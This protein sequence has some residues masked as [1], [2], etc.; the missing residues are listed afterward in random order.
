MPA[1]AGAGMN[2]TPSETARATPP[3]DKTKTDTPPCPSAAHSK[4]RCAP[5]QTQVTSDQ[6]ARAAGHDHV[7]QIPRDHR[8][9]AGATRP[10]G[11]HLQHDRPNGSGQVLAELAGEEHSSGGPPR[12][13]DAETAQYLAPHRECGRHAIPIDRRARPWHEPSAL[14]GPS[15]PVGGE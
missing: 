14:A 7:D 1:P 4:V 15:R 9:P 13:D 8:S 11:L 3:V 2:N 12:H 5:K 6:Q 10:A